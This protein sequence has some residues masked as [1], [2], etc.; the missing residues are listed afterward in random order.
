MGYSDGAIHTKYGAV[1]VHNEDRVGP[2]AEFSAAGLV[3]ITNRNG[4]AAVEGMMDRTG[5][6]HSNPVA[7]IGRAHQTRSVL[8]VPFLPPCQLHPAAPPQYGQLL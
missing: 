3:G 1:H 5:S 8:P 4:A 2:A 6:M 7:K